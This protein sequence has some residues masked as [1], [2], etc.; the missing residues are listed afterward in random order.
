MTYSIDVELESPNELHA[1]FDWLSNLGLKHI[2]D[3]R[4]FNHGTVGHIR[5]CTF[6]FNNAKYAEW[7]ALRWSS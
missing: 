1:A 5:H 2:V 3:W 6:Q 7:F 4:W